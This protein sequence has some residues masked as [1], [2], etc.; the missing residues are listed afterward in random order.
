MKRDM[1][2]TVETIKGKDLIPTAY[3]L[4]SNEMKTI[5]E[6]FQSGDPFDAIS[7]AFDYGF[8]LGARAQKAGKFQVK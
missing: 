3:D 8:V 4:D 5:Y 1:M 2:K 6:M 7:T